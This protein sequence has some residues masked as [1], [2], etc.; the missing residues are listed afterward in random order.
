MR[1]TSLLV[2]TMLAL[3]GCPGPAPATD[4]G[5]DAPVVPHDAATV[6]SATV[7]AWSAPDAFASTDVAHCRASAAALAATC[8]D[9]GGRHC[10]A[11]AYASYC[12]DGASPVLFAQALDCLTAMSSS[13]GGCRTFS[14]P[15][16]AGSCVD[17]VYASTTNAAVDMAITTINGACTTA[18]QSPTQT[19]PPLY[20]LTAAQLATFQDC[21]DAAVDCSAVTA[22]AS[23]FQDPISACFP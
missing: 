2:V 15:S 22:C 14:D 6:D 19:E 1:L 23:G 21:L 8:P 10:Q 7:D 17:G 4:A 18:T 13:S 20:A 12:N 3:A 16:G 9:D 5:T 11:A